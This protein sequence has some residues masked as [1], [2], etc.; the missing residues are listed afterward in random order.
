[1]LVEVALGMHIANYLVMRS[2]NAFLKKSNRGSS[3]I[4]MKMHVEAT[5]L[6]KDNHEG[7]AIGF[8]LAIFSKMPTPC[9]RVDDQ[10]LGKLTRGT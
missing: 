9:A 7:V 6:L 10:R 1:M 4:A 3:V 5:L 8:L 2:S